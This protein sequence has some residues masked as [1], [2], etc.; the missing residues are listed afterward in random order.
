MGGIATAHTFW[1]MG[2]N[3]VAI[4]VFLGLAIYVATQNPRRFISWV[5]SLLCLIISTIFISSLF[6]TSK[7][8]YLSP[9]STFLLRWRWVAVTF[10]ATLYLHL[11]SF[12]FPLK[13]QRYRRWGLGSAYFLS[14]LLAMA[15]LFTNLVVAGP[16]YRAAPHVIGPMPGP[17]M[18]VLAGFSLLAV[19][20]S[21]VG[22]IAM[23]R[24]TP[25]L[26]LRYQLAYLL[27]PTGLIFVSDVIHWFIILTQE[28]FPIP[29][30]IPDALLV[31]AAFFY[32]RVVV[33]YGSFLG[34]PLTR[35]G[36]FYTTLAAMGGL[37]IL[38][39]AWQLDHWLM[40]Y[41]NVHYP[42]ATGILVLALAT[43][44]PLMS[45]W[46][47]RRLDARLFRGEQQQQ[48][49]VHHLAE[50]LAEAP[51]PEQLQSELLDTLCAVLDVCGGYSAVTEPNLPPETLIIRDIQGQL[52]L[53]Q[54]D[55]V[56]RPVLSGPKP[57]LVS[58][59]PPHRPVESSWKNIA[60]LCPLMIDQEI[61]GI[62]ALG[63]K[64]DGRPF[65]SQELALCT[66]LARQLNRTG[67]M[68]DL[69]RKRSRRLEPVRLKD[70]VLRKLGNEIVTSIDQAQTT[71]ERKSAPL[72]IL[73]LGPLRVIRNGDLIA[74]AQWGSEKAKALLAYLVW[75]NPNGATREELSQVLWPDRPYEE[76]ANVF[77]VTLHR[78]R[79]VLQPERGRNGPVDYIE[80]DRGRYRLVPDAP[81]WLDVMAFKELMARSNDLNALRA[82]VELYQG[83]YME[84]MAWILPCDVEAEQRQLEQLYA[85]ALRKLA[86]HTTDGE[87]ALYLEKLLLVEPVDEQ[88]QRALITNYLARGR[89]DLARK[90]VRRWQ[91]ALADLDL[92]PIP[93]VLRLWQRA[94]AKNGRPP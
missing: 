58:V 8:D 9:T 29:H 55:V 82:A 5:F 32:A 86:A 2:S 69:R 70:Q 18:S 68:L 94:E 85:D 31:L 4:A 80:H 34:Q 63:E 7:P 72:E 12:Y 65:D 49:L 87:A 23:Y 89:R 16:L 50:L 44:F 1:L 20:G 81:Y 66:E 45:D 33:R 19:L 71:W 3:S 17:L 90:Q 57:Q 25:S 27:V 37:L 92:E 77:H 39:V 42:L 74:E 83:T 22:L 51:N 78:L 54:G 61:H 46:I 21:M 15:V 36:V 6:L 24:T 47:T 10:S 40:I 73:T 60:L 91:Q 64:R 79:R 28:S 52:P 11:L 14:T 75:K 76:T 62:L 93:G 35:R 13:W 88:A 48:T 67:A 53:R 56:S 30:E 38:Y 84:D 41:M 43:G 59:V 26:A